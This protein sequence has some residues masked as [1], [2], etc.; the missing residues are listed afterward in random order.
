MDWELH[1]Q[2]VKQDLAI[3][4]MSRSMQCGDQQLVRRPLVTPTVQSF[5]WRRTMCHSNFQIQ[6]QSEHFYL[7]KFGALVAAPMKVRRPAAV[8]AVIPRF[9]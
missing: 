7:L 3:P 2:A 4:E 8:A 6:F 5:Q 9:K 1:I